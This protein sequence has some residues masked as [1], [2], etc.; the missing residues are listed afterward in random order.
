MNKQ[1]KF[2][3]K[4]W[5][6]AFAAIAFW[7]EQLGAQDTLYFKLSNPWNT[8]KNINGKYTRKCVQEKDYFHVWDYNEKKILVTESYYTD[9]NFTK[10]IFCHKYFNEDKS[11][12]TQTRC[13]ENFNLHG[14]SYTYNEKG[15]TTSATLYNNSYVT[16]S[17]NLEDGLSKRP[18]QGEETVA[19]F[20]GGNKALFEYISK[21][22]RHPSSLKNIKGLVIVKFFITPGGKTERPEIKQSLHPLL[23]AEAIRV[24][25]KSPLWKP[26]TQ[27]GTKVMSAM[28]LPIFFQ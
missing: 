8:V 7:H 9:T 19:E 13:Y 15:D 11:F 25:K 26:A 23:D 5:I 17:W 16:K 2:S 14:Y 18:F 28:T 10:K 4:L 24:I 12:L 1:L 3:M 27:E 6:L 21:N 20:P 22:L